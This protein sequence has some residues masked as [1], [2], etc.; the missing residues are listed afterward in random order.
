MHLALFLESVS[1]Q[2]DSNAFVNKHH[3][4]NKGYV[5]KLYLDQTWLSGPTSDWFLNV[6][7][8]NQVDEFKVWDADIFSPSSMSNNVSDVFSVSVSNKCY[9]AIIYPCQ[10]L[11]LTFLVRFPDG[12]SDESSTDYDIIIVSEDVTFTDN[13]SGNTIYC[14]PKIG[15]PFGNT[16]TTPP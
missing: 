11:E 10:Y 6:T 14:S 4:W 13:S 7:F 12:I 2:C 8:G 16:T 3:T 5:G 15:L 1:P 9:N